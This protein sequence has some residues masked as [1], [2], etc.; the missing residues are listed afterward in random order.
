MPPAAGTITNQGIL[1]SA[2]GNPAT[3]LVDGPVTLTGGGSLIIDGGLSAFVQT[4]F[5]S[6]PTQLHLT[7]GPNELINVLNQ[8]EVL[9]MIA[10][11]LSRGDANDRMFKK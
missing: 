2:S 4:P 11:M 10:Y 8:D 1:R 9:D 6:P 3:F 7:P 5:N